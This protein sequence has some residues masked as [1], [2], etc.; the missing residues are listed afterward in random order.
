[1][2]AISILTI[3]FYAISAFSEGSEV[4]QIGPESAHGC[5][6]QSKVVTT[7]SIFWGASNVPEEKDIARKGAITKF[8]VNGNGN[9]V[10]GSE[11][12]SALEGRASNGGPITKYEFRIH[13][14]DGLQNCNAEV[15]STNELERRADL[16]EN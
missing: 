14:L 12:V 9:L 6:M 16:G 4:A 5:D 2:R 8:C 15:S 1:M 11:K 7:E 3:L 13:C 10:D